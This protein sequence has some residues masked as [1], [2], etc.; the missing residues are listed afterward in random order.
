[1]DFRYLTFLLLPLSFDFTTVKE[2][3][4]IRGWTDLVKG[5]RESVQTLNYLLNMDSLR[6]QHGLPLLSLQL[7]FCQYQPLL[8]DDLEIEASAIMERSLHHSHHKI[9]ARRD[10]IVSGSVSRWQSQLG[11]CVA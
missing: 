4:D 9:D 5:T 3:A 8:G 1:M 11:G 10:E 7:C 2:E 6:R